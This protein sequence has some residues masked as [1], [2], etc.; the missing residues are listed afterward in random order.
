MCIYIYIYS[1]FEVADVVAFYPARCRC[2]NCAGDSCSRILTADR[3]L[4]KDT[5]SPSTTFHASEMPPMSA[6]NKSSNDVINNSG[7]NGTDRGTM[8]R[9]RVVSATQTHIA[10]T[11]DAAPNVMA[12]G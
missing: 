10:P 4:P 3:R 12:V 8:P 7:Q 6:D 11:A 1:D 5:A 9:Y 2:A